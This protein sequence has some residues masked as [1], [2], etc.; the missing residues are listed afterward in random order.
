MNHLDAERQ[1]FK[2]GFLKTRSIVKKI[3]SESGYADNLFCSHYLGWSFM[4]LQLLEETTVALVCQCDEERVHI[5]LGKRVIDWPDASERWKALSQSTFGTVVR[6]LRDAGINKQRDLYLGAIVELRNEFVHRL[7]GVVPYPGDFN[8]YNWDRSQY[9]E[10][11]FG[12][13]RRFMR[14]QEFLPKILADEG[15]I[16]RIDLGE[17]GWIL[18]NPNFEKH[19]ES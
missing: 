6:L 8:R 4:R 19:L 9:A 12:Y 10:R 1:D 18:Q 14:A 2:F 15:L 3:G 13:G 11:V 16:T 17:A 7:N 5:K